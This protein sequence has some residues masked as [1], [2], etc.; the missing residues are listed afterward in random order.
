MLVYSYFILTVNG[1]ESNIFR[2]FLSWPSFLPIF[3]IASTISA[4]EHVPVFLF[5]HV[6]ASIHLANFV[7]LYNFFLFHVFAVRTIKVAVSSPQSLSSNSIEFPAS[8][9]MYSD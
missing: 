6:P 9:Y 7:V 3:R 2:I 8:F 1:F 4:F 5:R